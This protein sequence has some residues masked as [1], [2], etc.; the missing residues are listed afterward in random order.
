MSSITDSTVYLYAR[1]RDPMMR[2][3]YSVTTETDM[4]KRIE[5]RID[6][7]QI[8]DQLQKEIRTDRHERKLQGAESHRYRHTLFKPIIDSQEVNT[9]LLK[10][11]VGPWSSSI[12]TAKG[13]END[14]NLIKKSVNG[15][16][17]IGS[18]KIPL[19]VKTNRDIEL[20]NGEVVFPYTDGLFQLIM[21]DVPDS[22]VIVTNQDKDAYKRFLTLSKYV[23]TKRGRVRQKNLTSKTNK[24]TIK[25]RLIEEVK[26]DVQ[27]DNF[28]QG[29]N[30]HRHQY[31]SE[32]GRHSTKKRKLTDQ[33][34]SRLSSEETEDTDYVREQEASGLDNGRVVYVPTGKR[35]AV[36][37]LNL[38]LALHNAGNRGAD[39][40]A[41]IIAD[42][43][44][45]Q[46]FISKSR[47]AKIASLLYRDNVRETGRR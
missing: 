7:A 22:D 47:Y 35:E 29:R 4:F 25:G 20:N 46:K 32:V 3:H 27:K 38:L 33:L 26:T 6:I 24:D 15:D 30:R 23:L 1:V 9:G 19:K 8:L 41:T 28:R 13:Q 39:E 37:R 17:T 12:A 11:I 18:H 16:Y 14:I 45:S 31:S 43:L 42:Y 44:R 2:I 5:K 36:K 10:Q 40:E 34:R 21:Y